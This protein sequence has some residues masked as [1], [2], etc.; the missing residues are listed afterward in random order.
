MPAGQ[1]NNKNCG[2]IVGIKLDFENGQNMHMA[3]MTH[4]AGS[5]NFKLCQG[6][7]FL[8]LGAYA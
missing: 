7:K 5:D 8:N 1:V 2:T 3:N 6:L 4:H